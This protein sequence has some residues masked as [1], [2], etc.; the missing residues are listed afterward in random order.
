VDELAAIFAKPEVWW[1]PF[2]R[3]F[4]REETEAWVDR[5][6]TN[7]RERGLG[8]WIAIERATDRIV[9]YCGLAFPVFLPEIMPAVEV[10]YRLDPSC[11]GVGYATEGARAAL[12]FGFDERALERIV[13]IFE[14]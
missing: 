9:G 7:W 12:R 10:G 2:Q 13:A 3:G 6:R 14:V 4:T 1:F 8:Q 5:H 11:W